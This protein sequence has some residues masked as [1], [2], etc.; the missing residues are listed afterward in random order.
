VLGTGPYTF[1]QCGF[2]NGIDTNA[3]E[4][5][6]LYVDFRIPQLPIGNR[7]QIGG[8]AANV[9]PLHPYL[10]YTIDPGGG[11]VRLDFTDQVSLLL[12]YIQLEEDLDS[13]SAS[14]QTTPHRPFREVAIEAWLGVFGEIPEQSFV[15]A[16]RQGETT[17][18]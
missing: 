2:R 13:E 4:V 14:L 7:W 18:C 16:L 1:E 8:I 15:L 10:L 11:R 3:L 9:T 12:H 17:S 5:K 6:N